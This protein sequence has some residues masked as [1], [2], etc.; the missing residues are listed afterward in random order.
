MKLEVQETK[1]QGVKLLITDRFEDYRG[2]LGGI[3]DEQKYFAAGLTTK[4]VYDMVS[5][6]YKNVLRGLH[7]DNHTTKLVQCLYG[8]VY[9]VVACCDETSPDFGKWQSFILSD[10]NHHQLYIP[11]KHGNGYYVISDQIIYT[12]RMSHSHSDEQFILAW[13]DPR[14][15]IRW[16]TDKP[17]LSA[18][19]DIIP[20]K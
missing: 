10:K 11:P 7:Y 13:N 1:L 3:Y 19:D 14:Y 8:T 15:N 17:I 18:K 20:N 6:S 16:P 5:M 2:E 9:A 4:F 12:Y